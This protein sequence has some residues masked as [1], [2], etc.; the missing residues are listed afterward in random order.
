[1]KFIDYAKKHFAEQVK[2]AKLQK[3]VISH[4][5]LI[6][7]DKKLTTP[8]HKIESRDLQ[9]SALEMFEKIQSFMGDSKKVDQKAITDAQLQQFIEGL[10]K[11][12]ELQN[13]FYCQLI[14]QM[15][16]NPQR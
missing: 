7:F 15:T 5:E 16:K 13:E 2:K 10:L 12:P 1:M 9:K 11:K 3:K 6:S 14:K 4:E 8:L